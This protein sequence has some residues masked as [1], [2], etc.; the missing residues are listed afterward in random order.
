M[1]M[2]AGAARGSAYETSLCTTAAHC[3]GRRTDVVVKADQLAGKLAFCEQGQHCQ[4]WSRGGARHGDRT[5]LHDDPDLAANGAVDE[6]ERE[7]AG[8]P[9]LSDR[10]CVQSAACS[11]RRVVGSSAHL[12]PK[13]RKRL[14]CVSGVEER[15]EVEPE[16]AEPFGP[17]PL[18]RSP[19]P[20]GRRS[21]S[22]ELAFCFE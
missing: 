12:D 15:D 2:S 20:R 13:P 16:T 14:S 22:T 9:A 7:D 5:G 19:D 8:R 10:G 11:L 4:L 3:G 21:R 18:T 6:F 1:T 17:R